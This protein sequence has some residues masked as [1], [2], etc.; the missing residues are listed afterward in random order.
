[1]KKIISVLV[2]M[3]AAVAMSTG[4]LAFN[5]T[6]STDTS[7][8]APSFVQSQLEVKSMSSPDVK[9][10]IGEVSNSSTPTSASVEK[11][12]GTNT[13]VAQYQP[14]SSG[15]STGCSTGCSVGCSIGCR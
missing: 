3:C 13:Q 14:R 12:Q 7:F 5:S 10:L 11:M 8:K 6:S 2:A 15:C 4:A 9:S 1:M